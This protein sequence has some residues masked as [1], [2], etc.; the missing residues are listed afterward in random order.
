MAAQ[1]GG[2]LSV[3]DPANFDDVTKIAF[4]LLTGLLL[5]NIDAASDIHEPHKSA[6]VQ[7]TNWS[8]LDVFSPWNIKD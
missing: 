4:Y 2:F 8:V 7:E 3:P 6:D 5:D 1:D